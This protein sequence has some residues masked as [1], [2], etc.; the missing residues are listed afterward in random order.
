MSYTWRSE[1]HFESTKTASKALA[2][3]IL[4]RRE[5]EIAMQMFNLG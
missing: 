2:K 4:E 5:G 3:K 1:Q